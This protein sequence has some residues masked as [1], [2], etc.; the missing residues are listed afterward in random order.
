MP[1]QQTFTCSKSPT[2]TLKRCEICHWLQKESHQVDINPI[3]LGSLVK[4]QA[5]FVST[6]TLKLKL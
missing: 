3:L 6:E 2:E 4:K 1:I 5:P